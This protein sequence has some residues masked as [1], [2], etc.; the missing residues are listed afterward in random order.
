[1]FLLACLGGIHQ[2]PIFLLLGVLIFG[3]VLAKVC[4]LA[5]SKEVPTAQETASDSP[6]TCAAVEPAP[7]QPQGIPEHVS[8]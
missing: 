3:R 6:I 1:M 2:L 8:A 4:G 5:H 7:S